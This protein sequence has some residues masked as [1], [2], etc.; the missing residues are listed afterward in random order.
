MVK[1]FQHFQECWNVFCFAGIFFG[2][3]MFSRIPSN[4]ALS[5]ESALDID[6]ITEA[7]RGKFADVPLL[8]DPIPDEPI[9][10]C[11]LSPLNCC[12]TPLL[13][14]SANITILNLF[15]GVM[16]RFLPST[17]VAELGIAQEKLP[18]TN[19]DATTSAIGYV[20]RFISS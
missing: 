4:I 19:G 14:R 11:P 9:V 12:F 1:T 18:S 17:V 20:W 15:P 2:I 13:V 3:Q 6:S 5:C 8:F 16:G 7:E 10:K